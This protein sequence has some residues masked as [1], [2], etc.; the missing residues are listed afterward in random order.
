MNRINFVDWTF[1]QALARVK[2]SI[3]LLTESCQALRTWK[4][5]LRAP[6]APIECVRFKTAPSPAKIQY[7][8]LGVKSIRSIA[9]VVYAILALVGMIGFPISGHAQASAGGQFKLSQSV[10]WG[11]AVLPTG[12]YTYSVE[13]GSGM[14]VVRVQQI[15][16]R[17]TGFFVPKTSSEGGDSGSRG[18]AVAQIGEEM[19]VTSLR[20]EERGLVLNFSPPNA[21][22]E[23][24]RPDAT[25]TQYVSITKDPALG[26][27][28]I[29][30]PAGEK[31]SYSEAEKVYLAA[32]ETIEKEFNRT[33]PIRPRLTVHLHSTENNLHYPDRD[34]RLSRWDKNKFA[35]AVVELV[36]HDMIS[37]EDRQRLIKLAVA[38][39]G[40]SVS[41]CELKDCTN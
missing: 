12:E 39:A 30:N 1:R 32:C 9:V 21:D 22:A 33:T 23:V 35:E 11:S 28:T 24:V 6:I 31:I 16:G 2:M 13:S 15:G 18:I 34:L 38:Q 5:D 14:T 10:H 25:R 37:A 7:R 36:L 27:F 4:F 41:V 40:A 17:F 26:Y 20:V 3:L 19:F 29:F 8:R